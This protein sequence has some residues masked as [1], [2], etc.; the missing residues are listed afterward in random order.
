MNK[1]E[2]ARCLG[3]LGSVCVHMCSVVSD[4]WQPHGLQ[5]ARLF[6]PW[7]FP[8]KNTGVGCHFLCQWIFPTQGSNLHLLWLL[9]WEVGF[10]PPAPPEQLRI[11]WEIDVRSTKDES[12]KRLPQIESV[13]AGD[14]EGPRLALEEAS[15]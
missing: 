9:H 1:K 13:K 5:P 7:D 6:C 14:Q 3:S 10:L 15:R 4:S 8:C 2:G 12:M 11:W